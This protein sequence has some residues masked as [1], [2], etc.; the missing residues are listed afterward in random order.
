MGFLFHG[1]RDEFN[2]ELYFREVHQLE[3]CHKRIFSMGKRYR[4]RPLQCTIHGTLRDI[5][6][7]DVPLLSSSEKNILKSLTPVRPL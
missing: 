3:L 6:Q 7:M 1:Y 2:P 4:R 5:S